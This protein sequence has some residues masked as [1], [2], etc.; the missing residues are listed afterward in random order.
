[1]VQEL[2][3]LNQEQLMI[4]RVRSTRGRIGFNP[5]TW[6]GSLPWYG[7]LINMLVG[8]E[9]RFIGGLKAQRMML[10]VLVC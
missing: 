5:L 7:V 4:Y 8:L 1:M 3:D 2:V 6:I 9:A 10:M